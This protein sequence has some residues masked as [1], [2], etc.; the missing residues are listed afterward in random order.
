VINVNFRT[1]VDVGGFE[2]Q[3]VGNLR[4]YLCTY[5]CRTSSVKAD[6]SLQFATA[7]A[8]FG[9]LPLDFES[10]FHTNINLSAYSKS[11]SDNAETL[12]KWFSG[13]RKD[14]QKLLSD[15]YN[16]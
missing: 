6:L 15:V 10:L 13:L 4:C 7:S 9:L 12:R 3:G 8:L 14:Q 1:G 2:D 5:F 16:K 11:I